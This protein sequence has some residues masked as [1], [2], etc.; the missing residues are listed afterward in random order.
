MVK[1]VRV[2]LCA[3]ERPFREAVAAAREAGFALLE[4]EIGSQGESALS[5]GEELF[6][7]ARE[8][9]GEL[10]LVIETVVSSV[11]WDRPLSAVDPAGRQAA[12]ELAVALLE[13]ARWL[14]ARVLAVMPG[15]VSH[16]QRP[17]RR[18][19]PYAEALAAAS[20]ILAGLALEAEDRGVVLAVENAPNG[21]LLSP[22]EMREFIDR[23]HTPWVAACL[24]VKEAAR[25]GFPEDW[26]ETLGGRIAAVRLSGRLADVGPAGGLPGSEDRVPGRPAVAAALAEIGYG[27]PVIASGWPDPVEASR[28]LDRLIEAAGSGVE[29]GS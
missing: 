3:A 15:M 7:G 5:A 24:D 2:S 8:V 21:M 29:D 10:G 26:I 28:E 22:L 25:L 17:E 11:W 19:R 23:L 14:G 4:V 6:R 27:G 1:G 16:F 20:D 9:A 12:G 18:L 13:R